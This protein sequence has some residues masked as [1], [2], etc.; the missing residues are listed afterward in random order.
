L[1]GLR[2]LHLYPS[3]FQIQWRSRIKTSNYQDKELQPRDERNRK[4]FGWSTVAPWECTSEASARG[5]LSLF[6]GVALKVMILLCGGVVG[7]ITESSRQFSLFRNSA[8]V[9]FYVLRVLLCWKPHSMTLTSGLSFLSGS[10]RGWPD[11]DLMVIWQCVPLAWTVIE[12]F[13]EPG[14]TVRVK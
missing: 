2:F 1:N 9:F 6:N 8:W 14:K 13:M 5:S 3:K 7:V 11:I 10:L 4:L 12:C